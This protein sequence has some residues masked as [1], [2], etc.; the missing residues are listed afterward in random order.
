MR[1]Q[2]DTNTISALIRDPRGV[3]TERIRY[4]GEANVSTSIIVA[5]ELRYGAAKKGSV[6][7]SVQVELVMGAF[8]VLSFEPPAHAIY[9]DIRAQLERAGQLIGGN[10]MLI[11]AQA[12]AS[13]CTVVTDNQLEFERVKDLRVE[14]WL[15]A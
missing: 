5:A 2:L 12:I 9:G 3:V 6:R 1:Y 7:L 11:A 10:G 13:E 8:D 15:R 14:N 4:V